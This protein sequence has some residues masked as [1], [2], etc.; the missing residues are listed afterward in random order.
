ML[1]GHLFAQLSQILGRWA[2]CLP[3][4]QT[5]PALDLEK[6]SRIWVF[7]SVM[8]TGKLWQEKVLESRMN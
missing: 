1:S 5:N 6:L 8:H 4:T 7:S 3:L 2:S